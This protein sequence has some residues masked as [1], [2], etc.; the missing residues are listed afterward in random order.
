MTIFMPEGWGA[1]VVIREE[2]KAI[3]FMITADGRDIR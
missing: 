3:S 1:P 2:M